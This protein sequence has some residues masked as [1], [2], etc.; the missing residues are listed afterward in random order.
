MCVFF[1]SKQK[2]AY[3]V[4]I[5]DWSSDVCASDLQFCGDFSLNRVGGARQRG[6]A[7]GHA[8]GALAAVDQALVVAAE[9]LEPGQQVVA[10]G[11][12]LGRLQVEI[13]R[14]SG[15]ERVCQYV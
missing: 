2:T 5:S 3:E 7:Q 4:R 8:V 13:G 15:V 6:A 9:H 14:A 10:E 11:D 1:F 12:R